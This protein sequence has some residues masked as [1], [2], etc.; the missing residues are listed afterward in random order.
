MTC[1]LVLVAHSRP[2]AEAAR[3]LALTMTGG[4]D[5][6]LAVAAGSADGGIGTDAMAV[7]D[8]VNSVAERCDDVLVFVDLGSA[9]MSAQTALEFAEPDVAAR[10][11]ISRAPL[12]EGVVAA[13][14]KAALGTDWRG[15]E[16]EAR[17][18]LKPKET[19]VDDD[20]AADPTPTVDDV[21]T[22]AD[23]GLTDPPPDPFSP[24]LP[25]MEYTLDLNPEG[26]VS[27]GEAARELERFEV[28]RARAAAAL[29]RIARSY[30]DTTEAGREIATIVRMIVALVNDRRLSRMAAADLAETPDAFRVVEER[31]DSLAGK[32]AAAP[33]SQL[34]EQS[35]DVRLV[36]RLILG[37]LA[38]QP[39]AG[40]ANGR[41]ITTPCVI[42][43]P[44][45]DAISAALLRPGPVTGVE[46]HGYS[47][48]G[49]GPNIARL[50]GVPVRAVARD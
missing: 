1:G 37:A 34:R 14:A 45:L 49:H 23:E 40:V 18:G 20:L 7:L 42:V 24:L 30:D 19:L 13:A 33:T 47:D 31:L 41:E 27:T 39:L 9:I 22:V 12:V 17:R 11:H 25:R 2:L 50:L 5:I 35:I 38:E 16:A 29:E 4:R 36:S 21:D 3:D 26:Y 8:A 43:L 46:V 10:T 28:A 44:E 32:I 15:V 6:A 48:T